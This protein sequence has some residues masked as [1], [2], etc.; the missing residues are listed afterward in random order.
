MTVEEAEAAAERADLELETVGE[1]FSESI[2]AGSVVTSSPGEGERVAIGSTVAIE[3]SRG[4]ER[5]DVP[6]VVGQTRDAAEAALAERT[7]VPVVRTVFDEEVPRGEVL[8]QDPAPGT[9]VRRDAEVE[10]V[11]SKGREPIAV[12]DVVGDGAGAAQRRLAARG[13]EATVTEEFSEE[14]PLG[15]VISQDPADGTL[16]RGDPV[17]LVVSKGPP[18]VD[19]PSVEG[20][21]VASAT[22]ELE[23][24]GL[25]VR[26]IVLLP[27]GPGNVLRQ[28]PGAG[29]SVR[30]G[31]E[32][33]IY[34][35]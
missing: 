33:T 9:T 17:A 19:V 27:A 21:D 22:A 35:F 30:V 29:A 7:L 14:V 13:L 3:V 1:A 28:A 5:Y 10:L 4:P 34:V 31:S 16:F 20:Q 26:P 32:V 25:V 8:D 11:V 6:S 18:I 15:R 2:P 23:G 24:L 12:P